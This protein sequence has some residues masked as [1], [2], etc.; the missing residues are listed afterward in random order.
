MSLARQE[1]AQRAE[2]YGQLLADAIGGVHRNRYDAIT[3]LYEQLVR[4]GRHVNQLHPIKP[5]GC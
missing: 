2:K 5:A 3:E 4:D 1:A